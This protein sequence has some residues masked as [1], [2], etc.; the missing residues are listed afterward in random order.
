M[1]MVHKILDRCNL[2]L[3]AIAATVI[4]LLILSV[5][6]STLSRYLF[7]KPYA[8]LTDYA[9]YSLLFIAFLGAPWLMQQRG[10]T[11]IDLI[12]NALSE[13]KR[14]IWM[15]FVEIGVAVISAV[16]MVV[17]ALVTMN[18]FQNGTR[19]TDT[20]GTP[21]WILL[22]VIPIGCF[23]L[24]IQSIRC[25]AEDLRHKKTLAETTK[26]GDSK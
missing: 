11:N 12:P 13:H 23:F 25:A 8:F 14:H 10:H 17:G 3:A 18:A 15:G 1:R 4:L 20:F 22:I 19:L 2:I 21:K 24:T 16:V 9:T 6:F 7:N 26:G 5:C